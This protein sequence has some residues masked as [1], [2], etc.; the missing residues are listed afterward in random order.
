MSR[1][2]AWQDMF[3]LFMI[4]TQGMIPFLDSC[5]IR[6]PLSQGLDG[7]PRC[8]YPIT[9]AV[10]SG[11]KEVGKGWDRGEVAAADSIEMCSGS[12]GEELGVARRKA[13]VRM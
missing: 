1:V 6:S 13:R 8:L 7:S 11:A 4:F 3:L 5:S 9:L 12:G 10:S 2:D